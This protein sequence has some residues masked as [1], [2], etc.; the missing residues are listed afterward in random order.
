MGVNL[1]Q[2]FQGI[3]A[4]I[5]ERE[6]IIWRE[7]RLTYGDLAEQ[8]RRLSNVLEDNGLGLRRERRELAGWES[9]QD[10]V[11]LYLL[12]GPEYLIGTFGSYAARATA[13]NV[14]YRY[15]TDELTYL[16]DDAGTAALVYHARFA[17]TLRDVLPR[18]RRTPLLLQVSDDS[19]E[20]L[21]PEALDFARA[22]A[23][24]S[25]T[26]SPLNHSDDDLYMLYTGGTTGMPKG[27][28]WRQ[29]DLFAAVFQ[30][31][32][33]DSVG[34][35]SLVAVA[36]AD[37][38]TVRLVPNAPFMHGAGHWLALSALLGGGTLVINGTAG[39]LDP[40][41]AWR[42]V[43]RERATAMLMVGEAM[44][45]PLVAEL[46]TG[47]YDVSS[48]RQVFVG[49]A[50]TSPAT[51]SRLLDLLAPGAVV[52]DLAGASETGSGLV[53]VSMA[54][55]T[56]PL[57]VFRPGPN[58]AVLDETR[59]RILAP[60]EEEIGWLATRGAIPLGYLGDKHKTAETFPTLLGERWSVPGDR[61]TAPRRRFRR[62][63][64]ARLGHH[65]LGRREDLRRGGRTGCART[66]RSR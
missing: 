2:L 13:F 35:D 20:P 4:R 22:L 36:A 40:R 64:R 37:R 34:L 66:R 27:T 1:W 54:G 57:G 25:T 47:R 63:P 21:L 58:V 41:D 30:A 53:S 16:L 3:S 55:S 50:I 42:L 11:G 15:A 5:P 52:A 12:N 56:A 7:Q 28:L 45:R 44:A 23:D 32:G 14:N 29:G 48:L 33:T 51:K 9:G 65:Q 49:G 10:S 61:A 18:L 8:A 59:S 31:R 43:E 17:P 46:A 6:A 62:P 60:G 39:H 19:N 26:T 38:A 24:A